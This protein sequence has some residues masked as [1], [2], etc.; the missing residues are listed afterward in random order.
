MRAVQMRAVKSEHQRR[1]R[2]IV[3]LP[4]ARSQQRPARRVIYGNAA[5]VRKGRETS[6][7]FEC[8]GLFACVG[9]VLQRNH[10][11]RTETLP[12]EI[13]CSLTRRR[14]ERRIQH[15]CRAVGIELR[16]RAT[17]SERPFERFA[18]RIQTNEFARTQERNSR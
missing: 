2:C 3:R 1:P 9:F 8:Q 15:A 12:L 16:F 7:L 13:F 11:R 4:C 5:L 14:F 17:C 18:L 10:V 6:K